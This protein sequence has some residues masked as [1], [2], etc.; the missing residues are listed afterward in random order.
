MIQTDRVGKTKWGSTAVLVL[1][2]LLAFATSGCGDF[3][4][5]GNSLNSISLTPTSIFLTVGD[6]KQFTANGTTVNGDSQDVTST[7]KWSTSSS[8]VASVNAGLVTAVASGSATIT[9]SQDGVEANG[10]V[11]VNTSPLTTITVTGTPTTI[12]SGQTVQL[13]ATANFES[14]SPTDITNQVTWTSDNTS[15]ATVSS[16]GLVQGVATGTANIT[17]SVTTT[18]ATVTSDKFAINVQ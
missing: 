5:S 18:S 1:I 16:T 17:A 15:A 7:A 12:T 4:V 9:A 10:G 8:G 6:T 14:G 3:F 11:I 2:L 13:K